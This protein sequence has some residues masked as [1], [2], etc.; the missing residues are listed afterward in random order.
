MWVRVLILHH[1]PHTSYVDRSHLSLNL[2][3]RSKF[4]SLAWRED[5]LC[6]ILPPS[7]QESS[8]L[9]YRLTVSCNCQFIL[10]KAYQV[11]PCLITSWSL[12]VLPSLKPIPDFVHFNSL[13]V[14]APSVHPMARLYG[15]SL[16]S[17]AIWVTSL[18]R[19]PLLILGVLAYPW[20]QFPL[21]CVTA[22]SLMRRCHEQA[23][24]WLPR[25]LCLIPCPEKLDRR[26]T[27]D[28]LTS[29]PDYNSTL[30]CAGSS[31]RFS[32]QD[33]QDGMCHSFLEWQENWL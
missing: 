17:V 21:P 20:T 5:A 11:V 33:K 31:R 30:N 14:C 16:F 27:F 18:V 9:P 12:I 6:Q 23:F 10:T 28:W 29:Y 8:I 1:Q 4:S 25:K 2:I 32:S 26:F 7:D 24:S 19:P 13:V 15:T 3:M 22:L